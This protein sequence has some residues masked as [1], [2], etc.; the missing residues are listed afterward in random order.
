MKLKVCFIRTRLSDC[1]LKYIWL[2]SCYFWLSLYKAA[3]DA[4]SKS[5]SA[6]STCAFYE[7]LDEIHAAQPN[8]TAVALSGNRCEVGKE[9][10]DSS[11]KT[12]KRRKS[13][14]A[15]DWLAELR[16]EYEEREKAREARHKESME[17]K[18]AALD[19]YER[20]MGRLLD[21]L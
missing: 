5:G 4:N 13:A 3:K 21:K 12:K 10:C 17:M 7:E 2:E 6:P 9:N 1:K 18:R 14:N 8:I 11:V 19:I 16:L 20:M 15:P